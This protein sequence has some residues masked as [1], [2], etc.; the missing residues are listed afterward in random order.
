MSETRRCTVIVYMGNL[1]QKD[2]RPTK[3]VRSIC[4]RPKGH[5]GWQHKGR[6]IIGNDVHGIVEWPRVRPS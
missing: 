6:L 4:D 1:D 2:G 3:A 5:P